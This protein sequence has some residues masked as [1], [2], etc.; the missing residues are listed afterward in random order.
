MPSMS[1]VFV[2]NKNSLAVWRRCWFQRQT[3]VFARTHFR[4]VQ[5]CHHFRATHRRCWKS[6]VTN[7]CRC[8]DATKV[9][10]MI[11]YMH[12]TQPFPVPKALINVLLFY[13]VRRVRTHGAIWSL[14]ATICSHAC[15][16]LRA[17]AEHDSHVGCVGVMDSIGIFT[18]GF[19]DN[20]IIFTMF[21]CFVYVELN[22]AQWMYKFREREWA[23][24][25]AC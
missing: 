7:I 25:F 6:E 20:F 21:I 22:F 5:N 10:L 24:R 23:A 16:F 12:S 2:P 4:R 13:L 11:V 9:E 14:I 8:V 19:A 15:E 17:Y 3:K 1:S 18:R